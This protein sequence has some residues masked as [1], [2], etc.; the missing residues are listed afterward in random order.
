MMRFVFI[1]LLVCCVHISN[2]SQSHVWR[3]E[4]PNWWIDMPSSNLQLM[5]YG[6]EIGKRK[7]VINHEGI[8]I[9]RYSTDN[10]INYLFIDL[11]IK[12]IDK[13][14]AFEIEFYYEEKLIDKIK[15]NLK[16]REAVKNSNNKLSSSDVI[17]LIN[18]DRFVNGDVNND[19]KKDLKE[20]KTNR[21]KENSRHGGDI[22]GIINQ[23]NYIEKMG[24]TSIC[25]NPLLVNDVEVNSYDGYS[26]TDMY[27]IDPRFGSN[28]LYKNL[29]FEC[30]QKGIKLIKDIVLNHVGI[31]HWWMDDLPARMWMNNQKEFKPSSERAQTIFDPYSSKVDIHD[32][33]KGW[34]SEKQPDLNQSNKY[35][36][37]YL[38]QNAVW[39]VEYASLSGLR[40]PYFSYLDKGFLNKWVLGVQKFHPNLSI[41]ADGK[42]FDKSCIGLVQKQNHEYEESEVPFLFKSEPSNIPF[43]LD[44]PLQN[45]IIKSLDPSEKSTQNSLVPLYESLA[46]DYLYSD[47]NN[48]IVF[49]DN[50]VQN[51]SFSQLNHDLYAWKMAYSYLLVTRGI[52]QVYY[53]SELL[54]S[55]SLGPGKVSGQDLDFPGG[56]KGDKVNGFTNLGLTQQ[57]KEAQFFLKKLINW[58]KNNPVIHTGKLKHF[59]PSHEGDLYCVVRYNKENINNRVNKSW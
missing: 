11:I 5:I 41:V 16:E 19:R 43:L 59:A 8:S 40:V 20:K 2:I 37:T 50:N 22:Q 56:W 4:P 54:L 28:E 32:F 46:N 7:P 27:E 51:R 17:Y 38:I 14:I 49:L 18:T 52:P 33:T 10:N 3:V 57:Q 53:G 12:N 26:C 13:A 31:E 55:D 42:L 44:Y 34:V 47:P 45:S 35:V 30:S 58:R 1:F 15:Y 21:N 39:W 24:F 23:L 9:K 6:D 29:S 25:T 36:S 48:M